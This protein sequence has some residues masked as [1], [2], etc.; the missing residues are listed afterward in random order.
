MSTKTAEGVI[1]KNYWEV[2]D[3]RKDI[4][5]YSWFMSYFVNII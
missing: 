3:D 5:I 1:N 4:Q 2:E